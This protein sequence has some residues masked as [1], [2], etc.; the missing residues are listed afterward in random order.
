MARG[1]DQRVLEE[2]FE[3][4][5]R[6]IL[7]KNC[8]ACHTSSK[9]G[10]LDMRDRASLIH[11]GKHGTA[12]VPGDPSHSLLVQAIRHEHE[13]LKM[14]PSGKLAESEI[15]VLSKWVESGAVWPERSSLPKTN[16]Y[17]ITPEQRA[18]WSFRPV[19]K[20]ALPKVRESKWAQGP[21]DRFI[22]E[23]LEKAGLRPSAPADRRTLIRRVTYDLTGLPPTAEEV[24]AFEKDRA[25]QAY[26]RLIDRLLASPRYGERWGRMW[27]DLARYSDDKLDPTGETP[28]PNAFRYRDWVIRAFNEDM[29][30]D[31]F[32]KAQIAGDLMPDKEKYAGGLGLYALSPEFQDD[33]VDVT[34]RGF[35]GLT[36]ACAQCHDHKF[37]P[38]P[39][40]DY[41]SLLGVFNNTKLDELP[42]APAEQVR[43]FKEKKRR[44][45]EQ[46]KLIADF[47]KNQADQLA[48]IFAVRTADYLVAAFRGK[49]DSLDPETLRRWTDYLKKPQKEH[50][51]LNEWATL[52]DEASVREFATK[53][54]QRVLAVYEEKKKVDEENLIRLGG[55]MQRA[56][57]A[58]A[59]LLSLERDKYYLWRDLFGDKG[60]LHY[61]ETGLSRFLS[62][63]WKNH[64]VR[65]RADLNERKCELPEQY[66]FLQIISDV[67]KPQ[68]QHVYVRG[69]RNNQG[70]E[71]DA[72]FLTVLSDGAPKEFQGK[73]PR[74]ALAEAI[75]DSKDPLLARVMVNRVWL[76]HFGDAIVRT[77]SNFGQLGER[78]SHPELLDYLA[79]RLVESGWSVKA[80]HKEILLS[81]TYQQS[82]G[83]DAKAAAVD[84]ANRLFWRA[85]RRR[86]DAEELR[87]SLLFVSGALDENG[88][89][90][91]ARLTDDNRKRT[92]YGYVS[93][94]KLDTMLGLFDFP[95]PNSTSERRLT[96]NVPLQSLFFL[97]S[98]FMKKQSEALAKR[99]GEGDERS[100]IAKAYGFVY[101][102]APE[103]KEHAAAI[104]FLQSADW[105]Q[106]LQVLLSSNEFLFVN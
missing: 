92:V 100:R 71:V 50:P 21:I 29:P 45:E 27:L 79:A 7:A 65:M 36:V 75:A 90:R 85:N 31:R 19:V 6:P 83:T 70:E 1:A 3:S 48:K 55:S 88:G 98:P 81:S 93:R 101:G 59:D 57:L 24:Q 38:I 37:D 15:A 56:K 11:G 76:G 62:G 89:G 67:E 91:P 41:Y 35:L 8:F 73:A 32:V 97:N 43:E 58:G 46:E 2:E 96:T 10:G 106:Y 9:M 102:R 25:P 105:V 68:K 12:V 30:Y 69:D 52:K 34:T 87:D 16:A 39:Q 60:V 17:V 63:E 47:V 33:R 4:K 44:I 104:E 82:V 51:F 74:L 14:P 99:V 54:E 95:N 64:L 84:G 94:K 66:P 49:N 26:E 72:H 78:P 23:R 42:L 22:L 28:H 40:K 13:S 20:P 18:F 61:G 80:L 53:F 86:L 77:P 103:A 5:V